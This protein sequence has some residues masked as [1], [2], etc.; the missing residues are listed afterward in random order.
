MLSHTMATVYVNGI[1][2]GK[3]NAP[4]EVPCGWRFVRLGADPGPRWLASGQSVDVVC[5]GVT[6]VAIEP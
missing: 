1:A 4:L 5:R 6:R 2:T 3:T